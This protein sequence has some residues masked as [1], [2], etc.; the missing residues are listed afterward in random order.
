MMVTEHWYN[1]DVH[2][3]MSKEPEHVLEVE[4]ITTTRGSIATGCI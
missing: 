2:L 1:K 3:R 4:G